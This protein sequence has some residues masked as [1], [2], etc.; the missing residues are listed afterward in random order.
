VLV[1]QFYLNDR[2]IY[3]HELV[4]DEEIHHISV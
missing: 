2:P 1:I 4:E 3:D